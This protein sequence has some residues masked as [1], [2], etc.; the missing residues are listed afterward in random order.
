[1]AHGIDD[2]LTE[3]NCRRTIAPGLELPPDFIRDH[4]HVHGV[5]LHVRPSSSIS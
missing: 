4:N 3:S 1:M 5:R 2:E